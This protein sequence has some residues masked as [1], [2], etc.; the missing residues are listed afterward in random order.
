[1]VKVVAAGV[2]PRKKPKPKPKMNDEERHSRFI[3]MAK[4][5]EADERPE[6]FDEAFDRVACKDQGRFRAPENS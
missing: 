4:E 2:R 6:A 3:A 1:M 5:V